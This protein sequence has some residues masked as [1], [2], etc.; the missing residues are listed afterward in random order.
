MGGPGESQLE[1]DR[2]LIGQRIARLRRKLDGIVAMRGQHRNAR[3]KVPWPTVALVGYTNA[4]KSTLFNRLTGAG[5]YADDRLFATLDPTM[6]ALDLGRGMRAILSDTGFVSELPETLVAAFR[7]TLEEVTEASL[8]VHVRN[9][10]HPEHELQV[11]DVMA[12][13]ENLGIDE[14]DASQR[15]VTV[16]NKL[17]LLDDDSASRLKAIAERQD[18]AAVISA[19]TGEGLDNLVDLIT[20]R[21]GGRQRLVELKVPVKDG[22]AMGFLYRHAEIVERSDGDHEIHLKVRIQASDLGRF[23]KR[24]P[25]PLPSCSQ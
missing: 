6:R 3:S 14:L 21:L 11:A 1:I 5:V 18:D 22:A 23:H 7:A 17:D 24:F 9:A 15:M 13:L 4:G 16:Y 2:R 25:R 19:R 12:V 8:I 10:H 20:T